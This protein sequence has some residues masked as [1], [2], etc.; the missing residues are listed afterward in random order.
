MHL[1][2]LADGKLLCCWLGFGLVLL[3]YFYDIRL[4]DPKK[5]VFVLDF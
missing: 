4:F 5:N 1:N 3:L 2:E